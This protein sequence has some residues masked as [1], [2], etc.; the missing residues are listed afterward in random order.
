MK[1]HNAPSAVKHDLH[2][3]GEYLDRMNEPHERLAH[4]R[5]AAGFSSATEAAQRL[6]VTKETYVQHE[7]GIR[8]F[9]K[10]AEDYGRAFGVDP[11]WLLFGRG[12]SPHADTGTGRGGKTHGVRPSGSAA[13]TKITRYVPVLGEVRAGAWTDIP[14][15][16]LEA[17]EMLPIH[18]PGFEHAQLYALRV[19]GR[20]MDKEYKD[21]SRVVVCPVAEIGIRQG[22]HVIVRRRRNGLMETTLKEVVQDRTGI[23]LWPRSTD[24][25]HQTPIRLDHERDPDDGV[26]IVGVVV[27]AYSVR[28]QQSRPL[29]QI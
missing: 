16:Q 12:E 17:E 23:S 10:R 11:A 28:P 24:A 6:G 2:P 19:E 15:D 18:L 22:D 25:A 21:G 9:T 27:A 4:A 13:L 20:S 3:T 29:I 14:E 1:V 8:G 7:R 5:R 26:E